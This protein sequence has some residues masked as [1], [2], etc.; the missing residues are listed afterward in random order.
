[1][2]SIVP[3]LS[4]Q[5]FI[6]FGVLGGVLVLFAWG[7]WRYDL[8][9]LTAMV[10]VVIAGIVPTADALAGFGHP[11]VIT[12][13]AVLVISRALRNSGIVDLLASKLIPWTENAVAHVAVLTGAVALASAFMNNVGALALMLPVALSTAAKHQRSPAML[14]MPLAFGSILGGLTTLIGTP[15]NVIIAS[16]RAQLTGAPFKLFDY[17]PVGGVVALL[18]VAFV[19]LLGWRLIPA[20]RRG[21]VSTEQT[22]EIND[23]ITEVRIGENSPLVGKRLGDI[24]DFNSDDVVTVG[25][26]RGKNRALHPSDQRILQTGDLLIL[27]TDPATLK[28]TIDKH[29]LT[30][31]ASSASALQDLKMEDLR[32]VEAIVTPG[33]VLEGRDTQF[34]RRRSRRTLSLIAMARQG[35]TT[36]TR[37]R[38]QV[39][40]A[41]DILL[42]QGDAENISDTL[43]ELGLLP[44]AERDL[45]ITQPRRIGIALGIFVTAILAGALNLIALPVAFIGAIIAYVLLDILPTRDLYRHIDWPII[46]LLGAMI[47]VGQ[48]LEA[49]GAT[50]LIASAVVGLTR[51]LPDLA[52]LALVLIVTMCLSDI[53]NNAAT[54]L[55]MAPIAVGIAAQL[56]ANADAFLMAVALGAS[57]AFLTPIGH[58]SNTLVMGPGGYRFGDYWRMGLPLETV[59]VLVSIPLIAV[60]WPLH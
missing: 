32:L 38:Q 16:Y 52:I 29:K 25:L 4:V 44:L 7:R 30:L 17:T 6:V 28:A 43:G 50:T 18:G 60:A 39:F 57:C 54:A 19:A 40:Q 48:A 15:P 41:G 49:T 34:L 36:R 35:V 45:Q 11:A 37:L 8:V 13:A 3:Q 42:L 23:Y 53:I 2:N 10:V 22:F 59:I 5:Q 12:V 27:K 14:L 24:E 47:S 51:A 31:V 21:H 9:A 20:A 55:V 26:V 1:M 56:N 58:Q 33:S 46:V